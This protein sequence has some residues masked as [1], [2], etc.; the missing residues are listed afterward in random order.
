MLWYLD[1]QSQHRGAGVFFFGVHIVPSLL[2]K[3]KYQ[4]RRSIYT[5]K[6]IDSIMNFPDSLAHMYVPI[7]ISETTHDI[8]RSMTQISISPKQRAEAIH[9]LA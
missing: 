5:D 8:S 3:Q 6:D 7:F 1:N 9:V 4:L 2:K